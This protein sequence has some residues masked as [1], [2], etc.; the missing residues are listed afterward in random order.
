MDMIKIGRFLAA[1]R[2]EQNL[3]QAQL[4][5]RLGVTNK[6]VSRW[7]T[8]TYL[9]PAEQLLAM[10]TLYGVSINELLTG[11]RLSPA[12]YSAHAEENLSAVLRESVFSV[13]EKTVFFRKKWNKDHAFEQVT[14]AV[15]TVALFAA[16]MVWQRDLACIPLII[17]FVYFVQANNR[18]AAYVEQHVYTVQEPGQNTEQNNGQ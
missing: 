1:L 10:S 15:L 4:G 5:E 7:E 6:T 9:P 8:G 3:T 17:G 11:E 14:A 2:T 18:R 12:E 13:Q 16:G